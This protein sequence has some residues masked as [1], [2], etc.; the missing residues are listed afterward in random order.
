MIKE[1][2]TF[3]PKLVS[4]EK[5]K[6]MPDALFKDVELYAKEAFDN[7]FTDEK[8]SI[9]YLYCRKLQII[10]KRNW[11]KEMKEMSAGM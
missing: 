3:T 6:D 4:K 10:S 1:Q 8:V 2:K 11:K 9:F 5:D 7:K